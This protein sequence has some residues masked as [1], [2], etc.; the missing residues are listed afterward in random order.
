MI[1][2]ALAL[3]LSNQISAEELKPVTQLQIIKN[4]SD[5]GCPADTIRFD[6]QALTRE[7]SKDRIYTCNNLC[8][9]QECEHSVYVQKNNGFIFAGSFS[10][11]YEIKKQ[12]NKPAEILVK[13]SMSPSE[14]TLKFKDGAFQ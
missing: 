8:G 6:V 9:A 5:R 3:F 13:T 1:L 12:K 14:K 4:F 10:G 7:N 2:L 11:R